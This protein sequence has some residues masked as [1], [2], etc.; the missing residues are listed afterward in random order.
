MISLSYPNPVLNRTKSRT[1]YQS[2]GLTLLNDRSSFLMKASLNEWPKVWLHFDSI[3][4]YENFLCI[5]G[6]CIW[7][8]P[9]MSI[10]LNFSQPFL[11]QTR[12]AFNNVKPKDWYFFLDKVRLR[13]GLGWVRLT[14]QNYLLNWA[15]WVLGGMSSQL[16]GGGPCDYCVTPVPIGLGFGFGTAW[17]WVWV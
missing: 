12:P 3:L 6:A 9:H 10:W 7:G 11:D 8:A 15:V 17:V 1:K 2:L 4:G 13:T 16:C 5:W 14:N